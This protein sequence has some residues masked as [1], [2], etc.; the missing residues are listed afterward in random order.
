M[1]VKLELLSVTNSRCN[2]FE[3]QWLIT[4]KLAQKVEIVFIVLHCE[5][6][7]LNTLKWEKAFFEFYFVSGT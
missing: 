4:L 7:I 6:L 1:T 3:T 2:S 5:T